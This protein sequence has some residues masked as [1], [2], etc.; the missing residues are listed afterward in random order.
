MNDAEV[1]EA[2][3]D[4]AD[5][6]EAEVPKH[7]AAR[8]KA[9][10]GATRKIAKL[11]RSRFRMQRKS[12]LDSHALG[13]L[14]DVLDR[15]HPTVRE[16][17]DPGHD[18]I[19]SE[20]AAS[21]STQIY[22]VPVTAG[23]QETFTGAIRTAVQNGGE[24]AA[25]M[26][27]TNIPQSTESFIAEYLTDGGFSRLTGDLDKTTVD[28]LAKAV[29]DAYESGADFDGVV[30]AVKDSFADAMSNRARM[31]AQT[32][33]NDAWN[34]SVFHFGGE[35][36]ATMKS[37][38]IEPGACIICIGNSLQGSIPMEEDFDSGDDAP[39]AHPFCNCSLMVH[40]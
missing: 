31:I 4:L 27:S 17:E 33:L 3:N 34:Q 28:N 11:A 38:I 9:I 22:A 8:D 26:L 5:L 25:D 32:E 20:V 21:L 10:R 23:E 7:Q 12:V 16:A 6:I 2:A 19:V 13:K 30:Q 14:Q 36:G 40:A 29:A 39:T 18:S 24:A 37:W 35:A 1:I 15:L